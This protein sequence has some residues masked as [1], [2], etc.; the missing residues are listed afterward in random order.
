MKISKTEVKLIEAFREAMIEHTEK[1]DDLKKE[2]KAIANRV[3]DITR[4]L[5][6]QCV[7]VLAKV[8]MFRNNMGGISAKPS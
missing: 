6:P 1:N 4:Y 8:V 7:D 3:R 2:V 5:C